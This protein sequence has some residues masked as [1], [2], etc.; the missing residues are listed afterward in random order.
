M[1][2]SMETPYHRHAW[3]L[4]PFLLGWVAYRSGCLKSRWGQFY[5]LSIVV[6]ACGVTNIHRKSLV[7]AGLVCMATA[8]IFRV[9]KKQ[10]QVLGIVGALGLSVLLA[11]GHV[12]DVMKRALSTIL[13]SLTIEN[14]QRGS[15]GWED[16]FRSRNLEL[17]ARDIL[18]HP[19]IGRGFAFSTAE[20][21]DMLNRQERAGVSGSS[22][23]ANAVGAQHYGFISLM[24]CIGTIIPWFY[25]AGGLGVFF[26]FVRTARAL[27]DGYPKVLAAGLSGYFINNLFQWL[28]NGSGDQMLTV[29]IALGI[30][31]G[32]LQKWKS[33]S[34]SKMMVDA[35]SVDEECGGAGQMTVDKGRPV[36]GWARR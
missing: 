10:I 5:L 21:V 35:L 26:W 18:H 13:P 20:V 27:P 15:M 6:M 7:M 30:M 11:T 3:L 4:Y 17:A 33:A 2:F 19:F 22:D 28:F 14:N 31:M 36:N 12:P 8:W 16:D 9:E 25:A 32:L 23:I 1:S 34:N 29:S 24:T